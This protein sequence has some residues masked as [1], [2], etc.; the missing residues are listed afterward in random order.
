MAN[1]NEFL[2]NVRY[3]LEQAHRPSKSTTMTS[4]IVQ[5]PTLWV[6]GCG[7]DSVSEHQPP[8]SHD[9]RKAQATL[10]QGKPQHQTHQRCR[11]SISSSAPGRL[12]DVFHVG[13]LNSLSA[14]HQ[15]PP[16]IVDHSQ[17]C[18][19]P[20]TKTRRTRSPCPRCPP[21]PNTVERRACVIHKMGRHRQLH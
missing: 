11:H 7:C 10:L 5:Y 15:T 2:V 12:H 8:A 6:I 13:L 19:C 1:R 17:R 18:R 16:S 3:R 14:G 4:S 21:G 20:V 9:Q